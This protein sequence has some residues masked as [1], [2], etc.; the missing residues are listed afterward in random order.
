M[1]PLNTH[2]CDVL[3][4]RGVK[5]AVLYT[6]YLPLET[7]DFYKTWIKPFQAEIPNKMKAC[8]TDG[9]YFEV[10][11]SDGIAEAMDMLFRKIVTA[12]RLT[13]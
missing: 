6:T 4:T 1:E 9:Y 13:S 12:P 10:T 7:N 11:P 8:A 2:F 5:I 3:K